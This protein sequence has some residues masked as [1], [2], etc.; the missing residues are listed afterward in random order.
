MVFFSRADRC[1]DLVLGLIIISVTGFSF[2]FVFAQTVSAFCKSW[3]WD[4]NFY[5]YSSI[6]CDLNFFPFIEIKLVS[7]DRK[8]IL[9][10]GTTYCQP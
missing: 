8:A 7:R 2:V 9:N 1:G 6:D 10:G 4:H 5:I 3:E